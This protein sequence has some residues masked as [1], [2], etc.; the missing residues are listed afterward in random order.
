L[1]PGERFEIVGVASDGRELLEKAPPAPTRSCW[2]SPCPC[3]TGS[4]PPCNSGRSCPGPGWSSSPW[5]RTP[6]DIE[7][8]V[9]AALAGRTF[10]SGP[11]YPSSPGAHPHRAAVPAVG[12]HPGPAAAVARPACPSAFR[13]SIAADA[14][15]P[16]PGSRPRRSPAH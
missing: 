8:G 14:T 11:W 5:I 3:S 10:V 6:T 4:T 12:S 2:T 9:N 13:E 7:S 16:P 1:L 15:T